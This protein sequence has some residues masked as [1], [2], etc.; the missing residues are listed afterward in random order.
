MKTFLPKSRFLTFVFLITNLFFASL[1]FGQTIATD[2]LDYPPGA[3]AIITGTGFTPGET[4]TLQVLHTDGVPSGTDAQYHQ[5][6]TAIADANGDVSSTWWVPNDGD[7]AGAN[8]KLTADGVTSLRH[9]EWLFTDSAS[10]TLSIS[11]TSACLNTSTN[12]T[13]TATGTSNSSNNKV[14]CI[15]VTLPATFSSLGTPTIISYTSAGWT[16]SL[17]GNIVTL[18]NS[19]KLGSN[20]DVVFS[21]NATPTTTAGSP[22]SLTGLASLNSSCPS[23]PTGQDIY[24]SPTLNPTVTVNPILTPSVSISITSGAN[25]TCSGTPVIF[26][27]TPTNGGATPSYQWKKDGVN[28]GTNSAT[29]LDAGTA[30][31]VITVVMTSNAICPSTPTATS[32]AITL[33]VTANVTP[34]VIIA[35]TSGVNPTCNGSSVTFTAT[36]TNGGTPSYQW[37]KAGVD[38]AGQ[39]AST[40]TDTGTTGGSITVVMTSNAI[41]PSTPTATSNSIALAVTAKVTPS[42]SIAITSGINPTCNGSSVTFTATPSNGGTPSYQWKKAGVDIVGQTASTYTDPGTIA[43]SITVVMTSSLSC[44]TSPTA[45]SNAIGLTVNPILT[46]SVSIALTSGVNPTCSGTGVIFTAT[47][48]NGGTTPSYQ[49][50]K[51]GGNVGT[52]SATYSDAGSTGG[53]VTVVMTSNASCPSTPTSTSNAITLAVTANVTPSVSIAITSGV[54]PTCSGSAVTFTGTPT[55]GGTPSY[56]WKKAG[57]DIAGQTASTYTDTGTTGVSITVVMT[58]NAICVSTPTATSNSIALAVTA[59]V[60]PSVSIA[61]TSGIN[62]TCNGSS[63]TFTATPSNGG[64]PSYQ[65]KKAGVDIVGQTASTYANPG[66]TAGSITVLMTSSLSCVTS[67][68]ATSNAIALTVNPILTTSVSIGI[69]SGVNPTCSGTAVTFTATPTNGGTTPS[70]QWYKGTTAVGTGVTYTETGTT[71]GSITVVMTSNAICPSTPTATSNAITLSV[72]PRP[73]GII[74]GT[75]TICTGNSTTLNIAVAGTGPWSGTITGGIPF[76]GSSSP[77]SV[78]VSPSIATTYSIL[79]L[80]NANCSSIAADLSGSATVSLRAL[81]AATISITGA[82]PICSGST[83]LIKFTGPND[84]TVTYNING[85][86]NITASLNNGGNF[87]LTTAALTSDTTYNLVSVAYGDT[88]GCSASASGS[89]TITVNKAPVFATCPS[90]LTSD[91]SAGVCNATVSYTA[92]ATGTP[93][94]T[95][96]YSLSGATTLATTNGTGSGAT[97]GKGVT[98]VTI[99]ATNSCGTDTCS[100]TVTVKDNINPTITAPTATTGTTNAACT[101]TNV[102]LGTPVTADNCSVASVSND[103]PTAFPLGLTVV[104]WTVTDG[105]G[106]TATATQN[107]VVKDNTAPV[108]PILADA[109]GECSATATVPTTTDNC[110]GILTGTTS[111]ALTRSTQGT[112]VITWTFDDGNG[113]TTTATQNVVVKDNT[114]PVTPILADATGECSATATVPTTTD[115]C[116]GILTGTTSDALTRSTQGTSVITWT[117]DDGNGNTTTATQN[118]VVKDNTAPVTP[119]LADATGECSATA[120][121]PTTTD[122]CSGTITGT[123]SDALTRSTQGTSVITWTFDDGNGNTTT[124]TQNIV[125]KD[126]TAP[127]TPILADATGECSATA[128][129]PTT[130]DNCSGTIT[131]TTSDALTRS[132]QGTSVITWTFDDGNGNTTTATQNIVVK[133]NTAPVTPILAD[134]TG[135]CSATATVP[136]T[137]DNCSGTITGTTSDALT[138]STQGTSVITWTFDDGNG[139]TTTATQ[140]IVVK[141]NT[142]PVTPI[143]AD[144]T[145]ECS[146]TATVPTTTDNCSGTI[147]GTT[148]D[149]LTRSTQGTSV[150]TWTFDDGNGN[151]TTATQNIV[152]KDNTAPVTPILA[153]ATGECSATATVPTTTDNCSGILTGT[154]SDALTRSTQ[155]TSVITWTFDD[156]NGN[157]TTATQNV[158]VKDN[159]A[160]VTPILADATGECSATATVPTTTDNCSGILTGTTSDAL[161]RS[162]QGTSVITWTFDDGNGNTTTATQNIVV[163]DNTAP[164]TPILADATGEC[165]ATATVPTTTDNCSGIL[166]GTTSDALTRSTQGTSV[167]TWTFDDGNGNTTTATQNIVVKDNTAPVTPILADATGECSATATVPTTTDN[168]S[169]ILTGTTSDAL[170]RST[171]GTS[172]ITWTFDDGN[173]NTTTATQNIV[174][175][176]NTAP[177]TPI[178][179]DATGECSATATVPTTTDNC[180]GILTGTTSDALTRS[181]QGTSVI[182]WTFDDGNGNTTTATQNVVVKDNTAP[183]TPILADATGECSATATVPTTTD[184]C[185]GILTGTTSDALT[186]STQGTSVI[187]WTFDDGNGNTTTATQNIVVKDNTAP[188]TPILADATGECSATATVPTTTDNCSGILTGTTSDALTRS[189]QGTSVITWTFDDGNGNTTTATQNIVVKDNTAP[190]TPILADATGECSAT[191]TVPT[192]TDNCSGILT[193]TTS[194]ALTRSTQGTSVITWTF[195]DGNGNT[196]TATQNIVVKDNTAPVTPIL[197]D[198]TGECS[199]TAT[200]PTTTD[201]CSGILTGTTSDALTRSTQGTS[202]ITW[203][204]DD[205]NGNTTTATQNIVVKD[206][207]APVTPILADA[208]GECSATATVPT[209]TDN[210]SGILTGTTS[211]ALTRSTQ[212]TSVITWTFDDG[213]GNTTTATQNVVVKDNT[214]PVTP[215]LADATGECSATATVPTTTDNCSGTI[216]GTTSDALTRSTQGTSVITWTFDDGNGNTTTATQNIV[217]K[218][219]T[220]PVT[221]ILADA[222]G[223]CSA[224]ATVPT[225]TDN[226]SG[227]LTGTTSDA[228]TRSTQ[229]TSVITWTFDD[230]NGNTT[231]AT[232]NVVVKDNTAPVTPILADATGECSATAT[233]PTTTDNCSGILTGT[234]SDALTRS[235]QG[236][237][238][239]TWTFDDGNGNTTTATQN[240]VVK[241]NTAPVT[242]ILADATGE[243]SATATVPTTTDNCSGTITGTTSDALTRSTQGTSVI[244]WTFDDGNGN[245]TTATQNIVVKDNT[246]PVTPILADATGECSATA[247]VPTT[248]DNCSGIL[249]GTTS[250]ALTRSTQGTSVITW[251]FDD[252]NGNTTTATQN[253]VVKDNTA[254]VTPILADATGECSAT[255][256]VPTTTDNCSG[257]LTGTT[258]DA[259]TRSTQGTSVITWTFDDGNGNTT[260]ATQNV[261]VKDNTAPVTP[262]LADAT[263]ECS[264]TATVPTTTDNCS[265]T[266]TGTT[267]DALTRSTQGTSVITWTFDDGNGNTTTATQNIVVKDNT[268]PVTPILADATGECSATATVP[269]TTDNCSGILTGTTSDALTRST[270]GTSVITWTF[271]DGN[272]NTTTATQNIVVKDNTA[273]VTPILADA[274]G[275]CSATATVPT[276]TDNCSGIL[277]GTTSDALT[278][279]TQ[280][281][282][283]ITWT[284]DDGNGNTTTATQNVVVKDVTKPVIACP[285]NVTL[286]C[287]NATTVSANGS[288]TATDNCSA[289]TITSSD[290]STQNAV[291]TNAA[292]YNYTITR[293]WKATDVAGNFSTCVQTITVQDVTAPVWTTITGTLNRNVTCGS[294]GELASANALAPVATDNCSSV[295]YTKTSGSLVSGLSNTYTNIW[296]AK[297]ISNNSSAVFTQVITVTPVTIDASASSNPVAVGST[298]TLSATISPAVASVLVTFTLDNGNGGITTYT[299]ITNNFGVASTTV[300]NLPVEVYKVTAVA[301]A[302]CASSVAYLPIYDPNGGFVTG[303]GWISSPAGAYTATLTLTGKANFGFVSKYKKGSNIPEG[304]TEFQFQAGNLNFASSTYV[305]GSLVIAGSQAIYKGI[306]TINGSGSYNF[307]VSAVD[308]QISGGGGLDKFRIKIWNSAGVIYD[309]NKGVSDN[310]TPTDATKLGGGSIV[311]HEV[312]KNTVKILEIDKKPLEALQFNVIAY[313]NPSAQYFTIETVGGTTEKVE[314]VVFDVLGRTIKN[315]EKS[316]GQPILFGEELPTGVYIVVV[317]QGLNQKTIRLIK[318]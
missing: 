20:D 6:F 27:A 236:T 201:N 193:G 33:A 292:Y 263:G 170:T 191:A 160:P 253:V 261:V 142:A 232:Q 156:G 271:D 101:S 2:L 134:A 267:S 169:G 230:G 195:D 313:P 168:C 235:T 226:C 199:A 298:A 221:P 143:L 198:A 114:A 92:T 184:N 51:D 117:F 255:A 301:G 108:T 177:V 59:K 106:L 233:V 293:T 315:I 42:V 34:S 52:N 158:V 287:Q 277:T 145:G 25:P 133:D 250:D 18:S 196:T 43:G 166:T 242:P 138:R 260:T 254:P 128:T 62:P 207:T 225:T 96:T 152:V 75:Q 291:N 247:T 316:D 50:K 57:V 47:P 121:V 224:T 300:S 219:N 305:S 56:Q 9:A 58:S 153:D 126:N 74:S 49:W 259:L 5:P 8:F 120:T 93:A 30:G 174:V 222:T 131:G 197:A 282:S 279:S 217:V 86:S 82:N 159:T 1:A 141:D 266:I 256:T 257:I 248:T 205:G 144:A 37:K 272:G 22:F 123:T 307:M 11:P 180:S 190:V 107:I 79:T 318:Q 262:I 24:T 21:I 241:D 72:N 245:T 44:V 188:V 3:T 46:T 171:Q 54:N 19:T 246:A 284:F 210:C 81:P 111:D 268:A 265:G 77:I 186:R 303:G 258:S 309:N 283:V 76:S 276:T 240:V 294:A 280:G 167:I 135:E 150:I 94:P 69:T 229:G 45:I 175:K 83:T 12:F 264:A 165:S 192:T 181:T 85:G 137:T 53:V 194:D 212:G 310:G 119:I 78:S 304:N 251:T 32:N 115:N 231:T 278:R 187:T 173:G 132:T 289:V 88:P 306:G 178:L 148:S 227:I 275:E 28:V 31:G 70:Y 302:A 146:A 209:T 67:T 286:N 16:I 61:I 110:S 116:S 90:N 202:V 290:V 10:W 63:V 297:D 237:S 105:A 55:N 109:T 48:T 99:T 130:T 299:A 36:P 189:T 13:L 60:T 112:S 200:V 308:G 216:T 164:V 243:C 40:Y 204:F 285:A 179:A 66:T 295:I 4:V 238:V 220:A 26:T 185:S 182:T 38:I 244:T 211:D 103:A 41:C 218:D 95:Y 214:A 176:D 124:A 208:T 84:G 151:T 172:V 157:T 104:T 118:V 127:V 163:K 89:V 239:I 7:A 317:S 100:F 213:N 98:N 71:G 296:I 15:K 140:N 91:T 17:S 273:P 113:N 14:G 252:G 97:F 311:I 149:A 249:T 270:Q 288:A 161:T 314:M 129:V 155:G 147:T 269:T 223:E 122:N 68:T 183:V 87:T 154:T 274:T 312:N 102:V 215:I 234:T 39:T 228:L 203:T 281:T 65:W 80:S 64:T 206:N 29:Y 162:T 136:T 125:V 139:N 35:I 73:T 23:I